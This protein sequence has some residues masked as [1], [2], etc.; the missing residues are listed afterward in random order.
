MAR[1]AN[2]IRLYDP[3][4][5]KLEGDALDQQPR[6]LS[7]EGYLLWCSL[8][9]WNVVGQRAI[10]IK[11]IECA[12]FPPRRRGRVMTGWYPDW[13]TAVAWLV[14]A[15]MASV[16]YFGSMTRVIDFGN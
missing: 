7:G 9:R 12:Y 16:I 2:S 15:A 6:T 13:Q 14:V 4:L 3:K 11:R 8:N 1:S 5:E 10:L